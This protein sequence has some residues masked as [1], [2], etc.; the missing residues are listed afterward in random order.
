MGKNEVKLWDHEEKRVNRHI[1]DKRPLLSFV[2]ILVVEFLSRQPADHPIYAGTVFPCFRKTAASG[3]RIGDSSRD[4]WYRSR[5]TY[6][7]YLVATF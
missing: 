6:S 3:Q 7:F 1:S 4:V 5:F 2:I